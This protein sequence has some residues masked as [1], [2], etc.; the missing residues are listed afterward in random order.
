VEAPTGFP[1]SMSLPKAIQFVP[2]AYSIYTHTEETAPFLRVTCF[3][4]RLNTYIDTKAI[5]CFTLKLTCLS[6][7]ST[8]SAIFW[9]CKHYEESDPGGFGA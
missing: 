9:G 1:G 6:A 5:V 2:W 7:D 3:F 8:L 4:H